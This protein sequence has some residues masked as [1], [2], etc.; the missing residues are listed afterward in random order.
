MNTTQPS[1]R[2]ALDIAARLVGEAEAAGIAVASA[3]VRPDPIGPSVHTI[4]I[5]AADEHLT[6]ALAVA[7]GLTHRSEWRGREVFSTDIDG[8]HVLTSGPVPPSPEDPCAACGRPGGEHMA[9]VVDEDTGE[10]LT[11]P[12]A[13]EV[14][15][16]VVDVTTERRVR[17]EAVAR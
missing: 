12:L 8:V 1:I 7:L 16:R 15:Q 3:S 9:V 13:C 6:A 17:V 2:R 11:G 14:A 10:R 5:H 4:H